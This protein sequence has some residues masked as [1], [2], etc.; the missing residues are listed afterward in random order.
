MTQKEMMYNLC[1]NIISSYGVQPIEN[2]IQMAEQI[3]NKINDMPSEMVTI[4][5][6]QL[7]GGRFELRNEK[8][9]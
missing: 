3:M 7:L 5:G 4:S 6:A 1:M 8:R 9:K 2:V